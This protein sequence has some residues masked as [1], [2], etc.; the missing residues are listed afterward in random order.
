MT[1]GSGVARTVSVEGLSRVEGEGSLHVEVRDGVV[2]D[3]ALNIF[4]PPRFFEALLRGRRATE[5]P[6]ITARIC[7]ICPVAYQMSA[8]AAVENALGVEVSPRWP[9]APSPLLRG[10]DTEPRPAHLPAPRARLLGLCRRG[11]TGR[12]RSRRRRA[13]PAIK[14]TGN[15]IMST[16]GGRAIHPVNVRVGGFYSAPA[17]A[18]VAALFEPLRRA[19]DLALDTVSWVAGF[20]FPDVERRLPL[21]LASHAGPL[22]HRVGPGRP[23]RRARPDPRRTSTSWLSRSTWP[24]PPPSTP[25]WAV[26]STT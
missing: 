23:R 10:V 8:C 19:R 11:G 21:R 24:A 13:R 26:S 4:E 3:V 14:K 7:G 25:A 17:R 22:S 15:L 18:E 20:D 1:H 6:D 5:A 2:G 9:P 12:A 16:V